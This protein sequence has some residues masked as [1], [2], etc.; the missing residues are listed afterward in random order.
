MDRGNDLMAKLKVKKS[1]VQG[2]C[3]RCRWLDICGGN[4]RVRA[5]AKTGNLWAE[6]PQCYLT[7]E[8]IA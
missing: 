6:D 3:S 1:F 2:R 4:F 8:E 5:E 7:D